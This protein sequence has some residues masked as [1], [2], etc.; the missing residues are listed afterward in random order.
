[1]NFNV[2]FSVR[3]NKIPSK[4]SMGDFELLVDEELIQYEENEMNDKYPTK[5]NYR[6]K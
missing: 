1:M 5:S 3:W 4:E 6:W 2:I